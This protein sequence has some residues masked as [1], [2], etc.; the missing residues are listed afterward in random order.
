MFTL[1]ECRLR[2]LTVP[3]RPASCCSS[4][5]RTRRRSDNRLMT[6]LFTHTRGWD[7]HTAVEG[8]VDSAARLTDR[9]TDSL[10]VNAWRPNVIDSLVCTTYNRRRLLSQRTQP[11]RSANW[12]T[13]NAFIS[14]KN[15]Y[16]ETHRKTEKSQKKKKA[17]GKQYTYITRKLYQQRINVWQHHC[18][19]QATADIT[20]IGYYKWV[21]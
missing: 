12:L 6:G 21:Y 14:G 2:H 19:N 5:C 10:S 13:I 15:P 3:C 1:R 4:R 16:T 20:C 8:G 11:H 17:I 18:H 7:Q 9:L